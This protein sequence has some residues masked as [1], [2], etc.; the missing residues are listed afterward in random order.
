MCFGVVVH[1]ADGAKTDFAAC[2]ACL[3]IYTFM[4]S[5]GTS[6]LRRHVCN[7]Q[8]EKQEHIVRGQ[9]IMNLH[10]TRGKIS[11]AHKQKLTTGIADFC[12][13]DMRPFATVGGSGFKA[14][15]QTAL[16]IAVANP[17]RGRLLVDDFLATPKTIR[18]NVETRAAAG[19]QVLQGVLEKH[20]ATGE[21]ICCTLD[22]W[23]D[24]VRKHSYMSITVHYVDQNFKLHDRTLH[25]KPVR[26]AS[27]TAAVMVLEEFKEGICPT[28]EVTLY[29]YF[30]F[31]VKLKVSDADSCV[32]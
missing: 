7:Q 14:M 17:S 11:C 26:D 32:F 13:V 22:L 5:T 1:A 8:T 12:A 23:T 3:T 21:G 25:V 15:M 24:S 6:S 20:L 31:F 16:D 19:R 30:C 4:T 18:L 28:R 27:H 29:F 2:K 10:F 9:G